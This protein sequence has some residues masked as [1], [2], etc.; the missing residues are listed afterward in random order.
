MRLGASK[1]LS[2]DKFARRLS[3]NSAVHGRIHPHGAFSTIQHSYKTQ[4]SNVSIRFCVV[5]GFAGPDFAF[6]PWFGV[7]S[8]SV[9]QALGGSVSRLAPKTSLKKPCTNL[10]PTVNQ[11]PQSNPKQL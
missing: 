5:D 11:L 1:G 2:C 8:R 3:C 9:G 4:P 6:C 7:P 10:K